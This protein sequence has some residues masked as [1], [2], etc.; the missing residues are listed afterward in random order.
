MKKLDE[1]TKSPTI[2]IRPY[3]YKVTLV[4]EGVGREVPKIGTSPDLV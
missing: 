1:R 3:S 2:N 4:V